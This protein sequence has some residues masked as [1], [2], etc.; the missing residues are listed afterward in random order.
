MNIIILSNRFFSIYNSRQKIISSLAEN[1]HKVT[2]FAKFDG[3]EEDIQKLGCQNIKC[4]N[5]NF[6]VSALF[7]KKLISLQNL[8][9]N[10]EP[11]L[12]HAFNPLPI[13]VSAFLSSFL[14][15]KLIITITGLGG[16]YGHNSKM[17][18]FYNLFY[19][20]SIIKANQVVFQ[21]E[22]DYQYFLKKIQKKVLLRIQK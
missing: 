3:F 17:V 21:N 8:M 7:L 14:K 15:Y 9:K 12:V 4:V 2:I 20:F 5:F 18:M 1:G 13:F 22:D 19:I 11:D 6:S 10:E 16:A